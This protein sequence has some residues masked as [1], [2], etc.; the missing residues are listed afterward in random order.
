M[1]SYKCSIKLPFEDNS[2]NSRHDDWNPRQAKYLK[3][4]RNE[5][6]KRWFHITDLEIA[7]SNRK[8]VLQ[9][10]INLFWQRYNEKKISIIASVISATEYASASIMMDSLKKKLNRINIKLLGYIWQRDVGPKKYKNHYHLLFACNL[11]S[12]EQLNALFCKNQNSTAEF[13]VFK[14]GMK[15]YLDIKD[16]YAID[17]GRNYGCSVNVK[18]KI[19][20]KSKLKNVKISTNVVIE[21]ILIKKNKGITFTHPI[22]THNYHLNSHKYIVTK[23]KARPSKYITHR[24]IPFRFNY[25]KN[26]I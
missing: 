22:S 9:N 1:Y 18:R 20:R 15:K 5:E 23:T 7:I 4:F 13:M 16:F 2:T 11:I 3:L 25:L 6:N 12:T 17:K 19:K 24:I 14:N 8:E 26:K 10:F 21:R